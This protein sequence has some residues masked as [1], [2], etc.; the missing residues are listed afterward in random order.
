MKIIVSLDVGT[1]AVKAS[2]Y[3]IDRGAVCLAY[4]SVRYGLYSEYPEY[5]EQDTEEIWNAVCSALRN[6]LSEA[7]FPTVDAVSICS[8]AQSVIAVDRE[9]NVLRRSL[10][11]QDARAT[12]EMNKSLGVGLKIDGVNIVKTLRTIYRTGG[13]SCSAKDSMWKILWIRDHEPEIYAKTALFLDMKDF[14]IGKLTGNFVTT[15]DDAF[16]TFLLDF[17]S[18]KNQWSKEICDLYG[19]DIRRLPK[20]IGS[21]DTAG[22]VTE[23][24]SGECGIPAGTEV[25]GGVIDVS[26]IQIGSG[27][28][29]EGKTHI[30]FGSSGW[31]STVTA[32]RRTSI[33]YR[34]AGLCSAF[35]GIY[36]HYGPLESAGISY[37]W[38]KNT[39]VFSDILSDNLSY[40]KDNLKIL[41]DMSDVARKVSVG[42]DGLMFAPWIS[43]TRCPFEAPDIGGMFI[44]FRLHTQ[45]KHLV[46]A[47]M[48]GICYHYRLIYEAEKK[49]CG[50]S[51][52]IRFLGGGANSD[53]ITQ[54]LSDVLGV[55]VE[56]PALPQDAGAL[57]AAILAASDRQKP[58]IAMMESFVKPTKIFTPDPENHKLY[59]RFYR[60]YRQLYR[61]DRKIYEELN[62]A[63]QIDA[64]QKGK[65][66]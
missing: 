52:P 2:V 38:A 39:L 26:G 23:K 50:V 16:T 13:A 37:E 25:I 17:R 42:C 40:E 56:V 41:A 32:K 61:S 49:L 46:R 60:V 12:E 63:A 44:N 19:V 36:N 59:D 57:G 62:R 5:A 24:A 4:R 15:K 55:T 10:N 65:D 3:R 34:S 35:N 30:Y 66:K 21:T 8:Q 47:V 54:I 27:A 33:L 7:G 58:D 31:V 28:I 64:N 48:E 9:G 1:S 20:I 11:C 43:G 6:T 45:Q 53:V 29:A 51:D 14:I 18:G 22:F